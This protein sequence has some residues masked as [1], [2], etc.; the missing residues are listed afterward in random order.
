[1]ITKYGMSDKL[2][3]LIFGNETDEVFLGRDFA[4]TRNYSEQI[5]AEIDM[6]VKNVIDTCYQKIKKVL[7]DN[8][9]KLHTVAVTLIEKEKLEGYEFE[10]LFAK[11]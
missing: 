1:M 3:N 7:K 5:A 6:E 4:H 9:D 8:M 10:E 2:G 11:A